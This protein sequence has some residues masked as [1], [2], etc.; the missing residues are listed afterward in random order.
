MLILLYWALIPNYC[1]DTLECHLNS[2]L[3]S[4]AYGWFMTILII[5]M[6]AANILTA[7]NCPSDNKIANVGYAI[8]STLACWSIF[9]FVVYGR[10]YLRMSFANVFGYLWVSKKANDII[11]KII[12]KNYVDLEELIT[13]L[14]KDTDDNGTK[15]PRDK[16]S[17]TE[18]IESVPKTRID[19]NFELLTYLRSGQNYVA[20]LKYVKDFTNKIF[21]TDIGVEID[22]GEP[23]IKKNEDL[24][25]LLNILYTRDVIG[26]IILFILAGV[27]CAYLSEY[28]IKKINC[29]Y[30]TPEEIE[31]GIDDYNTEY[32]KQQE[33]ESKQIVVTV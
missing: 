7:I 14:S 9:V 13:K 18:L 8:F 23:S 17:L 26:E 33:M 22:Q 30:K 19:D 12:P 31:K 4:G 5:L 25:E 27:M 20:S 11:T 1:K 29:S 28:L 24:V 10:E 6:I 21:R 32:N 16:Q 2:S 15:Y 3:T